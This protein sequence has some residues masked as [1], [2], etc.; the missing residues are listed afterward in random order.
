MKHKRDTLN[1]SVQKEPDIRRA[2]PW[3]LLGFTSELPVNDPEALRGHWVK[4]VEL[5]IPHLVSGSFRHFGISKFDGSEKYTY[6]S[7]CEPQNFNTIP[8]DLHPVE[9]A[10]QD[11][12]FFNYQGHP[13]TFQAALDDILNNKLPS[14]RIAHDKNNVINIYKLPEEQISDFVFAEFYIPVIA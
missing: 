8:K 4:W 3:E 2:G 1:I 10:E 12:L 6:I 11:F 7:A 14:I 5:A 13:D 9:I